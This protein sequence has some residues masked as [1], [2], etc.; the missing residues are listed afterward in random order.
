MNIGKLA[1]SLIGFLLVVSP[2]FAQNP[3]ESLIVNLRAIGFQLV[4]LWLLT[5]AVVYGILSHMELPKSLSAR[6]VISIVSAFM[7][8]LA[9]AGT[10]AADFI[11]NLVTS[12]ILV[13]FGLLVA[14]IFLEITGT[15]VGGEHIFAKHPK[16]FA[17]ALLILAI[18][19]FIGAGGLSLLNIPV[20]A[21]SDPLIAIIFFLLIMVASI[22]ILIKESGGK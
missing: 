13:A 10:Q 22:W 21:L 1:S 9:A 15:K 18:L 5:L 2:A 19:I 12:S 4:L 6:G 3:V 20:F 8:L 11:S 16:F 7:V 14:M 17:A